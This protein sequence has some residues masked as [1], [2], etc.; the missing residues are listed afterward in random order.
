[1]EKQMKL[2]GIPEIDSVKELAHFW[3]THDL[4]D[5]EAD[6]QEETEPIFRQEDSIRIHLPQS[7]LEIIKA[8][9]KSRGVAYTE[10][11]RQWVSEKAE[12]P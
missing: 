6:L 5:F 2:K 9:A 12:A 11:I 1:M 3:D 4:T 7:K 10:L 8:I